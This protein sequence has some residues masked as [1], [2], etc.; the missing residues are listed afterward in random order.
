MKKSKILVATYPSPD[1][2]GFACSVAYTEL[3][4]KN[5][6]DAH[7]GIFGTPHD[8]AQF[9]CD[10]LQYD[11]PSSLDNTDNFNQIILVDCSE[12]NGLHKSIKPKGVIEIV[13][14]RMQNDADQF[15]NAMIQIE[16]VGSAATLIAEKFATQNT[17]PSKES[18]MLLYSAIVS[19]T[20]NFKAT[21]TTER[22]RKMAQWIH[23]MI[24]IPDDYIHQMFMSKSI[25]LEGQKLQDRIQ[26]DFAWFNIADKKVSIIQLEIVGTETLVSKHRSEIIEA[27]KHALKEFELNFAFASLIDLEK[28]YNL[29]VTDHQPSQKLLTHIFDVKF[30]NNVAKRDGLIMRKE[31]TPLI[32]IALEA[33]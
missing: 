30:H 12:L 17:R 27:S 20:L 14:H 15:P 6:K 32:K 33:K 19:N 25:N 21:V 1:L 18:A 4:Q 31:I 22:D 24:D 10:Y 13:D 5:G 26:S 11:P 28:G 9:V 3:L 29:F 16:K 8:E 2:D 7:E 23:N